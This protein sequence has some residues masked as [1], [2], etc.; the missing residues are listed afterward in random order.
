VIRSRRWW[1]LAVFLV[2]PLVFLLDRTRRGEEHYQ[3]EWLKSGDVYLRAL[4][5]G[6]GDTTVLLLH[7]YGESL[8]AYRGLIAPLARKYSVV[9]VDLPGSGLSEKPGGSYTLEAMVARLD[10][11]LDQWISGPVV[12]I[13]H[14]MGG[15]IAAALAIKRPDRIIKTVLIAPAGYGLGMGLTDEPFSGQQQSLAAWS[16]KA[17]EF[18]VPVE[19]SDWLRDPPELPEAARSDSA[20]RLAAA[21]FLRDFDF[22]ALANRF[23]ELKQPTLL[24][25]GRLDPLIPIDIGRKIA[26]ELP[27]V[28]FVEIGNSWHRPHVEQPERVARDILNFISSDTLATDQR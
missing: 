24:I 11:A 15:E 2:L 18:L 13:G 5:T 1:I 9:A 21:A 8:L 20:S 22:R 26:A 7:G 25:W 14:S 4:R 17:R 28:R 6:T 19:D 16:L 27:N 12:I 23:S 10:R 3:A